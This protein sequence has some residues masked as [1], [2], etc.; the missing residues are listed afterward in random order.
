MKKNK[1]YIGAALVLLSI[2]SCKPSL[3]EYTPSAGSVDFS[4]YVAIGNSLTAGY[5]D[6]GLYLEGQKIAYPN[7]IAEQ[8]KQVGGGEF[9][10]PFFSEAQANG[11][12]YITL[13]GLVNGQPVTAQVTDKL[14]YRPDAPK[15]LTKYTD[16]INNL[17]VPGMRM[18]LSMVAGM[19][20]P[21]GNPFFERLLPDADAMKTYYT[22]ATS[23]N[24]TFFS[25]ALGNN[26]ALG[27]A[28]NGG[29][30]KI[31][32]TT[33]QP[34]PTTVLTETARFTAILNGYVTQLASNN[35]KGV[36]ATIPDVTATPYFTTVTR[37]ALLAA[38]NSTNPPTPVKDIYI[39][40]KS[41]PRPATDKDYFVLPFLSA[42]LLGKPNA[43]Q[44]PYGLHP[45]NPVEDKYVLDVKET[46]TVVQRINEFN[47]A[48]KA[49][50]AANQ[51]AVA[52]VHEFLNNVKGGVRIN[53]L[54]VSA[55]YITGNAFSL[56][57]IHLTPIGNALM[58]NIFINAINAHYG[59]K[60]PMV[61]VSQYR[62]VKIPDTAT[63]A[64]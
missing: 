32:P 63:K 43:A 27:W 26:D 14:A 64:N 4:K 62:G 9:K 13:T 38:V 48:I 45:L 37:M 42:G 35:R 11:S 12:G 54:A 3:D 29:V 39:A 58:A 51:L 60:I 31:N 23:Q 53:G 46:E 20:S 56:D 18:D 34:D 49:A 8:L 55:K 21:A 2:A 30:V 41:G 19:A 50:A 52:D 5:A 57:G 6:G 28:T 10:S 36:L 33:Q 1:L 40:T 44:I 25:F 22:Y 61:D 59:S 47:A 16:P 7:L 24:H 15:L 17:G